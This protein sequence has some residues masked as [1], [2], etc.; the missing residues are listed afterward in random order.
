MVTPG[1]EVPDNTRVLSFKLKEI[2]PM[3]LKKKGQ[4]KVF[5]V[6]TLLKSLHFSV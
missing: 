6:R 4:T 1:Q 2:Q 5:F 3:Y